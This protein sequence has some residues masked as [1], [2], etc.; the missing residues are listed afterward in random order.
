MTVT[1]KNNGIQYV[2]EIPKDELLAVISADDSMLE[3]LLRNTS[4]ACFHRG[5][6]NM[7]APF[8]EGAKVKPT[9]TQVVNW[10]CQGNAIGEGVKISESAKD[11]AMADMI[12]KGLEEIA[13]KQGKTLREAIASLALPENAETAAKLAHHFTPRGKDGMPLK[14]G[15]KCPADFSHAAL[16]RSHAEH[17]AAQRLAAKQAQGKVNT[18]TA[19]LDELTF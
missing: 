7:L 6:D 2:V 18:D 10:L 11:K 14:D 13:K 12:H 16:T 17:R 8:A 15:W 4:N 9:A 3:A 1:A 19:T 5:N